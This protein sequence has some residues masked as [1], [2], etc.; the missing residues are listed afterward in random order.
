MRITHFTVCVLLT[1]FC[2]WLA[3]LQA[4]LVASAVPAVRAVT[5]QQALVLCMDCS[6]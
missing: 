5:T 3:A 6:Y 2:S 4:R 1:L